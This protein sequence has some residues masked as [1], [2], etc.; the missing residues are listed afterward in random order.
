[1]EQELQS[2]DGAMEITQRHALDEGTV[3]KLAGCVVPQDLVWYVGA[4]NRV[5]M[6]AAT[7]RFGHD[8]FKETAAEAAKNSGASLP[9]PFVRL[10]S[11]QL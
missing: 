3:A 6:A 1:M 9:M 10:N 7:H 2:K 5:T 8:I 4:Y 11:G